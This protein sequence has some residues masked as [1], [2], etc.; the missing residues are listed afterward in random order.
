MAPTSCKRFFGTK[1]GPCQVVLFGLGALIA[2][3]AVRLSILP[4]VLAGVLWMIL[5]G[6][7]FAADRAYAFGLGGPPL[8]WLRDHP[9]V[10]LPAIGL[11]MAIHGLVALIGTTESASSRSF[12]RLLMSV[13]ERLVGLLLLIVGVAAVAAGGLDILGPPTVDQPADPLRGVRPTRSSQA[14]D[15]LTR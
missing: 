2:V 8:R 14:Q 7:V 1:L 11:P 15:V 13:P 4:V 6:L 12:G 9:E 10:V 5:G 3:G